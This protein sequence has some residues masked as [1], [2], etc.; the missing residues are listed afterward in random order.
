MGYSNKACNFYSK[1][2]KSESNL[3]IIILEPNKIQQVKIKL[4]TLKC[5][6]IF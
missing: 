4:I 5:M 2:G 3:G 6:I 1:S